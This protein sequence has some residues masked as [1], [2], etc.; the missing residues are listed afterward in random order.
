M[1]WTALPQLARTAVADRHPG[2][3]KR[4]IGL[5]N[6]PMIAAQL[7]ST[8]RYIPH[9]IVPSHRRPHRDRHAYETERD[10]LGATNG[11]G[12]FASSCPTFTHAHPTPQSDSFQSYISSLR[13]LLSLLC[14]RPS[15]S[16]GKPAPP[17]LVVQEVAPAPTSTPAPAPIRQ[18]SR[19]VSQDV[20]LME[21]LREMR[22]MMRTL[23]VEVEIVKA[24][25]HKAAA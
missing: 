24:N 5:A 3:E 8:R 14:P 7:A 18:M 23:E 22:A 25:T 11:R 12:L 4:I 13:R 20:L 9:T 19:Q 10:E 17:K 15:T 21:G 6:L 16:A 2:A 1:R